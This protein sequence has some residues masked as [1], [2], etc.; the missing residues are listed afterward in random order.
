M[1]EKRYGESVLEYIKD[2]DVV[3]DPELEF[4]DLMSE[5]E[6]EI[7]REKLKKGERNRKDIVTTDAINGIRSS[8]KETYDPTT[9][10]EVVNERDIK[11]KTL[12]QA[13]ITLLEDLLKET[14][15]DEELEHISKYFD[16][17]SDESKS[18]SDLT[19]EELE[20]CLGDRISDKIFNLVGDK[21]YFTVLE[22]F[23]EQLHASYKYEVEY[24]DDIRELVKI[25]KILNKKNNEFKDIKNGTTTIDTDGYNEL[26]EETGSDFVK[27]LD[28]IKNLSDRDNRMRATYTVDDIEIELMENVKNSLETAISFNLIKEKHNNNKKKYKK[29]MKNLEEVNNDI[30]NWISAIKND[31][32]TIYTLPINGYLSISESRKAFIKYLYDSYIMLKF[33]VQSLSDTDIIDIEKDY[34]ENNICTKDELKDI[35]NTIIYFIYLLTKAFKYKKINT[36]DKRR[37][38]SY[39]L[40]ILSKLGKNEYQIIFMDIIS[41][42][43]N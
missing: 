37:I 4:D 28:R 17:L 39:T 15:T 30:E 16:N 14:P 35:K 23:V 21:R 8:S 38:L 2:N 27:I 43:N 11:G 7:E 19:S 1:E 42:I 18:I 29:D 40:D 22:R 10:E 13:A 24:N 3:A 26:L 41:Y 34:I 6:V 25:S 20:D 31:P 32:D 12:T 5:S 33:G 9:L 36:P